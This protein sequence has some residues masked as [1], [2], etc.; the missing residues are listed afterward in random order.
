MQ[1]I[2]LSPLQRLVKAY[3]DLGVTLFNQGSF[4]DAIAQFQQALDVGADLTVAQQAK[5]HFNIG[6]AALKLGQR[7]EAINRFHRALELQ[8]EL[9]VA[10]Q[11]LAKLDYQADTQ[12]RGYQ[13]TQDWFGRNIPLWKQHLQPLKDQEQ[14]NALEIGS[15]EGRSA[16]WLLENI[17][18]HPTARL[19]CVDSFEGNEEYREMLEPGFLE[20]VESR[21]DFNIARAGAA[22]KVTKLVGKSAEVLRTLPLRNFDLIYIDGSHVACDVLS[23]AVLSWELLKVGGLL[24]FDDYDFGL[25]EYGTR[26]AIDAFLN[27][28]AKKLEGVHKSH[29]VI[30]R[31]VQD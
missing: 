4:E 14:L 31:K 2:Q 9:S 18:T 11:E 21:F 30:V 3:I 8:P 1:Q 27:S 7:Q 28:F 29:Q 17:L 25:R 22:E 20:S 24:I 5:L 16:C 12:A 15:W 10:Q 19:T 26:Y 6:S 23:D 13:F